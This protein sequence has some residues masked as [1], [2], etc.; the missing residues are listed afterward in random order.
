MTNQ[1]KSKQRVKDLGEVFTRP[2]EVNAMLDLLPLSLFQNPLSTFLEPA[3]G[4]GNFLIAILERK[5]ANCP[6]DQPRHSYAL[7]C[8]SSLYGIDISQENVEEAIGRLHNCFARFA[9]TTHQAE[10]LEILRANIQVGDTLAKHNDITITQYH[11]CDSATYTTSHF[12]L[13]SLMAP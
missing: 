13:N 6:S 7:K 2:Q 1:I 8:L 12:T 11:W 5:L 9:C 10:A 4:T 3:C